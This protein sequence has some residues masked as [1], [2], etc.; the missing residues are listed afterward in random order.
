MEHDD[1]DYEQSSD[2]EP[3][4]PYP[5]ASRKVSAWNPFTHMILSGTEEE[6]PKVSIANRSLNP[7]DR[8]RLKTKTEEMN[9]PSGIDRYVGPTR[10]RS[11]RAWNIDLLD[12]DI[13]T[14]LAPRTRIFEDGAS[15]TEPVY[16]SE[17]A[18]TAVERNGLATTF[19]TACGDSGVQSAAGILQRNAPSRT[20]TGMNGAVT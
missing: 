14:L 6:Q 15:A 7:Q 18:I 19:I 2:F 16:S 3:P 9:G 12:M 1:T 8:E 4:Q 20:Q 10:K 11:I 5:K 13:I 17:N